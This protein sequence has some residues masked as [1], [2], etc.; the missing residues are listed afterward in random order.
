MSGYAS[1][2]FAQFVEDLEGKGTIEVVESW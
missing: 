2:V 1:S